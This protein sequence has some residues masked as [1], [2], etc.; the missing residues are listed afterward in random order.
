MRYRPAAPATPVPPARRPVSCRPPSLR[1]VERE[2]QGHRTALR[3]G[4]VLQRD[5]ELEGP[6]GTGGQQPAA[7]ADLAARRGGKGGQRTGVHRARGGERG[8][9]RIGLRGAEG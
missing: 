5:V 9:A 7:V 3:G 8:T 2:G 1:R 6:G 4:V